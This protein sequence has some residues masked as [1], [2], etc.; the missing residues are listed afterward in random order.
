M[1]INEIGRPESLPAI[2]R[3]LFQGMVLLR[4]A[5]EAIQFH[6]TVSHW[7]HGAVN[8][9]TKHW[10]APAVDVT[11]APIVVTVVTLPPHSSAPGAV[12]WLE[13]AASGRY[14]W[15]SIRALSSCWGAHRQHQPRP[16]RTS[17]FLTEEFG[18]NETTLKDI[19][20]SQ[21]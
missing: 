5:P 3:Y 15:M 6:D 17:R 14:S 9:L 4:V 10:W 1:T 11:V 12:L 20:G 16:E 2:E 19:D 13:R 18:W 21:K 7:G 8:P